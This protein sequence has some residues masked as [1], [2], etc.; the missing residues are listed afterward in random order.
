MRLVFLQS[1]AQSRGRFCFGLEA[2]D[3]KM[4]VQRGPSVASWSAT[5]N[6]EARLGASAAPRPPRSATH[7]IP[8]A[9][10]T[11]RHCRECARGGVAGKEGA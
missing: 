11:L 10:E 8:K 2:A 3:P 4:P 1:Q 5:K 6:S 7:P 9:V